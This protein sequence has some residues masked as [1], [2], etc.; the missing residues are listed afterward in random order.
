MMVLAVS[1]QK[2]LITQDEAAPEY[3][4]CMYNRVPRSNYVTLY[5]RK[6][7]ETYFV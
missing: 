5:F 3:T 1:V 2:D 7:R 6:S 4:S